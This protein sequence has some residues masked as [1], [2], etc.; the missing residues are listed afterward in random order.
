VKAGDKK[1][2]RLEMIRD[3]LCSFDYKGKN[4]KLA[5]PDRKLVFKWTEKAVLAK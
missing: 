1:H 4:K 5:R 2:A 3:L